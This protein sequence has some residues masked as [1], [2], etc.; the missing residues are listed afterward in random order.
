MAWH[1]G[2]FTLSPHASAG[3]T[4]WWGDDHGVQYAAPLQLL[5]NIP[6]PIPATALR[7]TDYGTIRNS[8]GL[9]VTYFVNVTNDGPAVS[10]F[11]IIGFGDQSI[12]TP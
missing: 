12:G 10:T 3:F 1:I 11:T 2:S 7:A 9:T 8:D 4:Y 5:S 6:P